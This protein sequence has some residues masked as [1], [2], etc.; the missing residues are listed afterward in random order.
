MYFDEYY[1]MT[2]H[3]N[4]DALMKRKDE[5]KLQ[6]SDYPLLGLLELA[7]ITFTEVINPTR[8]Q[9]LVNKL[10]GA[11]NH[12]SRKILK[13]WSQNKHIELRFDVRPAR[14]QDPE[15]MRSGTNIW[16]MVYDNKHKVSTLL[17]SRSRGFVWFFSFLAWFDKQQ[18]A[19]VRISVKAHSLN[20]GCRTVFE[21]RKLT[22][23]F[24]IK[25]ATSSAAI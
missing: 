10:E 2:G 9:E 8:T 13:Y 7:R 3:E 23:K 22:E 18:K 25:C 21:R 17:G 12:L 14:P 15:G 5:N 6:K 4:I 19:N 24:Y 16:T 1:Q 11:S 20:G